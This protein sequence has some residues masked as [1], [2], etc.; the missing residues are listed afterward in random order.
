MTLD[1]RLTL[2]RA[3]YTKEEIQAMEQPAAD[4]A[5][6]QPA[7]DPAPEQQAAD[8]APEQQTPAPAQDPILAALDRLTNTIISRNINQTVT[9]PAERTPEDAL[10]EIIAPPNKKK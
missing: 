8:P 6:E 2:I 9:Q 1:E 10:A 7:A 3:G 4:P 5:P